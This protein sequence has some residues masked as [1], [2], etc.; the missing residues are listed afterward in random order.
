[1][2][3]PSSYSS[4][5]S[6][7]SNGLLNNPFSGSAFGSIHSALGNL[8]STTDLSNA[9]IDPSADPSVLANLHSSLGNLNSIYSGGALSSMDQITSQMTNQVTPTASSV[10]SMPSALFSMPGVPATTS[11]MTS[12]IG[13]P[14]ALSMLSSAQSAQATANSIA[15]TPANGPQTC[16][17]AADITGAVKQ[18]QSAISSIYGSVSSEVNSL[19]KS[20]ASSVSSFAASVKAA[21]PTTSIDP[22]TGLKTTIPGTPISSGVLASI[23]S[24]ISG[25]YK[26]VSG[27]MSSVVSAVDSTAVSIENQMKLGIAT[28]MA[29][30]HSDPCFSSLAQSMTSP[31]LSSIVGKV[32]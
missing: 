18:V 31:S 5:L 7:P 23:E 2:I 21:L 20:I 8:P 22:I 19:E 10:S 6:L 3:D 15:G 25:A 9:A 32:V 14:N 1:M 30:L 26:T 12:S 4:I 17:I 13:V 16:G 11:T 24:D 29:K 27:A 28:V